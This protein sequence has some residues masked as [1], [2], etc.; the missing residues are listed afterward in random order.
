MSPPGLWVSGGGALWLSAPP[1]SESLLQL[2]RLV[3][4][5]RSLPLA[6]R[7]ALEIAADWNQQHLR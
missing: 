2:R 5:K 1:L 4:G 3:P 7:R 6:C